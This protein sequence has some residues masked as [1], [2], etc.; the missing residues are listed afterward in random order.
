MKQLAGLQLIN[1]H[2]NILTTHRAVFTGSPDGEFWYHLTLVAQD[3]DPVVMD[4]MECPIG[5]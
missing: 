4:V 5:W 2:S 3:P 1:I